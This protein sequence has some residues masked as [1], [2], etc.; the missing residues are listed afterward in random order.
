MFRNIIK[1]PYIIHLN[2]ASSMVVSLY[3]S[4]KKHVSNR[5]HVSFKEP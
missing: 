1:G 4:R 2:I 3:C 5:Q